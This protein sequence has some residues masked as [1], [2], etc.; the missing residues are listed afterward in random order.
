MQS[1]EG[2]GC[3]ILTN[4]LIVAS[5]MIVEREINNFSSFTRDLFIENSSSYYNNNLN[6]WFNNIINNWFKCSVHALGI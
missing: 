3:L 6:N 2:T 4:C 5:M 1:A